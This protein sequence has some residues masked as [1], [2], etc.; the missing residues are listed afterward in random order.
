M[1]LHV[2]KVHLGGVLRK[3]QLLQLFAG[4]LDVVA[5]HFALAAVFADGLLAGLGLRLA[6]CSLRLQFLRFP[7]ASQEIGIVLEG[8]AGDSA[9]RCEQFALERHKPELLLIFAGQCDGMVRGVHN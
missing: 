1:L 7:A 6:G 9:A 8:T 2:V 4:D 3:H 5:E